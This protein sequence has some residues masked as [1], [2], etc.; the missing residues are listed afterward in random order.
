MQT[1]AKKPRVR[2]S[3][4]SAL[5][6]SD[7]STLVDT[8]DIMRRY[9]CVLTQLSQ[10]AIEQQTEIEA[11]RAALQSQAEVAW[12]KPARQHR[13]KHKHR[14]S[15]AHH[16]QRGQSQDGVKVV[17]ND[18]PEHTPESSFAVTV[19]PLKSP[20]M[21]PIASVKEAEVSSMLTP[22]RFHDA[23]LGLRE[24]AVPVTPACTLTKNV[25]KAGQDS[26]ACSVD[27]SDYSNALSPS[28]IAH[29]A[30]R[31]Q[32]CDDLSQ[33]NHSITDELRLP[34]FLSSL[35]KQD[36]RSKSPSFQTADGAWGSGSARSSPAAV[37][38][39]GQDAMNYLLTMFSRIDETAEVESAASRTNSGAARQLF[40]QAHSG[41]SASPHA[42]AAK[43]GDV[44]KPP[45][46]MAVN[47][48]T[49]LRTTGVHAIHRPNRLSEAESGHA[50]NLATTE[51]ERV[52][53]A[54]TRPTSP[55]TSC[56]TTFALDQSASGLVEELIHFF[57]MEGTCK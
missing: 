52:Q 10:Q 28:S 15:S 30:Q 23:V 2:P 49:A 45:P 55:R 8:E 51:D 39:D 20:Q 48:A 26:S 27:I 46:S 44:S 14:H 38:I 35:A 7:G 50:K 56:G 1:L 41:D 13:K 31:T 17:S 6:S 32:K 53:R 40:C 24:A 25:V 43:G 19:P 57:T 18:P 37:M 21:S 54:K 12:T 36:Y 29:S 47:E 11:L 33:A 16:R 34:T 3:T 4:V 9:E 42:E 22:V 5:S